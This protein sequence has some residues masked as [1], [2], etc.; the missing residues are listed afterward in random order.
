[1]LRNR[2]FLLFL[3]L[4]N[5][6]FSQD[7]Q[8]IE[9]KV[10]SK[11]YSYLQF[12]DVEKPEALLV[13]FDGGIGTADRINIESD[14]PEKSAEEN[15]MTIGIAY[16]ESHVPDSTYQ[17]IKSCIS[18]ALSKYKISKSKMA[19]GGF[20]GGGIV[21][22]RFVERLK[23]DENYEFMPKAIFI[24]DSPL[25]FMEMYKGCLSGVNRNC[26]NPD[27]VIAEKESK[28]L[29]GELERKF[30]DPAK[31]VS[32][33][34]QN[35]PFSMSLSDGGNAKYLIDIPIRAYHEMDLMWNI[36]ER[37]RTVINTHSVVT[38]ELINL[39][40]HSG[41]HNAEVVVSLDRGKRADGRRHPHS[42]SIVDE[43][44]CISWVKSFMK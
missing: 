7:P 12:M 9:F 3:I 22:T 38:S 8:K 32:I 6:S 29:L 20:S 2:L 39:L 19:L 40:Y 36:R 34:Y 25:D 28:W 15:I 35:S 44:E 30:G 14:F 23:Q 37:C 18:H 31:N 42:W 16:T 33:Y 5:Q 21:V 43:K 17:Y 27:A 1:M 24:I 41:N 26:S 11:D 4:S 13:L 10:N